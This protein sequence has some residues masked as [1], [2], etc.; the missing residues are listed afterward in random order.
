MRRHEMTPSQIETIGKL[1][2]G[3]DWK[4]PLSDLLEVS[5]RFL[6]RVMAGVSA[7]PAG[8]ALELE[9]ALRDHANRC[10]DVLEVLAQ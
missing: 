8:W 5:P 10:D 7:A 2:F 6:R 1:L 3:H 4:S 9:Q